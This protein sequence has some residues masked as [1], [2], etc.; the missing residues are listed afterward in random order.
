MHGGTISNSYVTGSVQGYNRTGG[1][2]GYMD[3]GNI[4]SSFSSANVNGHDDVGG[5]VGFK[6]NDSYISYS[7]ATGNI[8]GSD[9]VGGFVGDIDNSSILNSYSTGLAK[10]TPGIFAGD[11]DEG[12]SFTIDYNIPDLT[13]VGGHTTTTWDETYIATGNMTHTTA[14]WTESLD[15]SGTTTHTTTTWTETLTKTDNPGTNHQ[16][17]ADEYVK[18]NISS[19][20]LDAGLRNGTVQLARHADAMTQNPVVVDD[21]SFELIDWRT[22]PIIS[23]DLYE[24][25][26][27]E[28]QTLYEKAIRDVNAQDKQLELEQNNVETEYKAITSEK[29]S[30]N[31]ILDTN[32][33]ASFKYFG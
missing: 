12:G 23:D 17:T 25:N 29:E 27:A 19:E 32:I 3:S 33:K 4:T 31:K 15:A 18:T 16:Y 22:Q 10:G 21:E 20:E 26:D 14:T 28:A 1:I 2:V 30:V 13:P 9:D 6:D 8:T 7:Y 5:F 24:E 11:Y